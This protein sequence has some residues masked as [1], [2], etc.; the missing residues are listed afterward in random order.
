[1]KEQDQLYLGCFLNRIAAEYKCNP[2][3]T[4]PLEVLKEFFEFSEPKEQLKAF[5]EF[6]VAALTN[7][8]NWERGSPGNRLFYGERLELLVEAAYLI[9][10]KTGKYQKQIVK[11]T[12]DTFS[13]KQF[14]M[15]LTTKEYVRPFDFLESFFKH[16]P[17]SSWKRWLSDFTSSAISNGSV[18]DEMDGVE[19]FWFVHYMK[20]LIYATSRFA[21]I[22]S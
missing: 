3:K 7:H 9:S 13:V 21:E 4:D 1:M 15:P 18:S 16:A 2:M 5:D 11:P 6:C 10:V 12:K 17:I 8:Y 20:K 19:I 14:P 22:E